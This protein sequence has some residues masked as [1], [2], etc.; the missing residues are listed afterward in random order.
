MSDALLLLRKFL[1]SPRAVGTIAPSSRALAREMVRSLDLGGPVRV[2]ELGPGTGA[3][4]G[5]ILSRLGPAARYLAVE[6]DEAFAAGIRRRWP[7]V[8][9]ACDSA[10]RLPELVAERGLDGIDHVIS[11][12]PFA[13]L[14]NAVTRRILDG[15]GRVL[16][17]GGTFTTFQYCHGYALPLAAAFRREMRDRMGSDGTS[18]LVMRNLPPAF[19]LRWT[20]ARSS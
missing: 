8:D 13:S 7:R 20:R 16:C 5:H 1:R 11:G 15:V 6:I 12:L 18:H 4:T 9:C 2:V 17:P 19:V 3:F 10:E 14:P